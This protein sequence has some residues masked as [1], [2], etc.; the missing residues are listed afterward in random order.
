MIA[1]NASSSR[2]LEQISGDGDIVLTQD[3][4]Y[5]QVPQ[6]FPAVYRGIFR[7]CPV[8]GEARLT[9][10]KPY[11]KIREPILALKTEG[12]AHVFGVP[13]A[14]SS[15]TAPSTCL[16]SLLPTEWGCRRRNGSCPRV[17]NT[18]KASLVDKGA[19]HA[20]PGC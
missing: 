13:S 11:N 5:R 17:E 19:K 1:A 15:T 18:S 7:C 8:P 10:W 3:R 4:E 2:S 6:R 16:A 9:R 12:K 20:Q 14:C